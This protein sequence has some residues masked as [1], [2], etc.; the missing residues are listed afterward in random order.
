MC[1]YKTIKII[2]KLDIFQGFSLSLSR[3]NQF[4]KKSI[5]ELSNY[6]NINIISIVQK[7]LKCI[8]LHTF[9]FN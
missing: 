7:K 9:W 2:I 4:K 1:L 3:I 8:F 5:V 6:K